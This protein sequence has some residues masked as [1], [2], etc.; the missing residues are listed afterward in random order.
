VTENKKHSNII[1]P[2]IRRAD[3][4]LD[5]LVIKYIYQ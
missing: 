2:P 1:R 3:D 4:G 5:K